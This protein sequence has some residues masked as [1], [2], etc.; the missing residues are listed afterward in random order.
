MQD[1]REY[2]ALFD[3]ATQKAEN[4]KSTW[5][6]IKG[7]SDNS[8]FGRVDEQVA[9]VEQAYLDAQNARLKAEQDGNAKSAELLAK[10]EA[11]RLEILRQTQAEA[12]LIRADSLNKYKD[13]AQKNNDEIQQ[14]EQAHQA[15]L[16][17]MVQGRLEAEDEARLAQLEAKAAEN[18]QEQEMMQAYNDWRMEAEQTYMDFALDAAN[19]LKENL[20][21]G[22]ADA[23][24]NGNKLS[25]VFKNTG[26]QIAQMFIQWQISRLMADVL[27][28]K[29]RKKELVKNKA[30]A[31]SLVA[32]AVQKSI[33]E[34]GPVA[35][36]A[37]YAGATTQMMSAGMSSGAFATGG[38]ITAPMFALMGEGKTDEAV[39][40][41]RNGIFADLLGIDP[42]AFGGGGT[43]I[44][45]NIYGDINSA[46]DVNDLFA[47]LNDIIVSG[48]RG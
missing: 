48:R 39:I 6:S 13:A 8:L 35:A 40:P 12:D 43:V 27:S 14:N 44:E 24:V 37:A 46:A 17:A 30:L 26:K 9:K 21:S 11:E 33:A 28:D 2:L 10:T 23:I 38:V 20:S 18:L 1:A 19:M 34:L 41:L 4:F 47:A 3:D 5:D 16:L 32:P 7:D 29:L 25:D 36:P 15:L 45:Q 22:I 42:N 31:Q